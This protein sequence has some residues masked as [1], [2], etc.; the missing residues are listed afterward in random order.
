MPK[1]ANITDLMFS[2][3]I[4]VIDTDWIKS[5]KMQTAVPD[6]PKQFRYFYSV[7]CLAWEFW[8]AQKT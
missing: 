6:L 2:C 5:M 1:I 7:F 3:K 8:L 4:F